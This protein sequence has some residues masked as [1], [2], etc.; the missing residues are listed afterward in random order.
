LKE[1]FPKVRVVGLDT[2]HWVHAE[3]PGE[4]VEL[5]KEFVEKKE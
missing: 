5:V 3:R 2:G 4:F 1:F